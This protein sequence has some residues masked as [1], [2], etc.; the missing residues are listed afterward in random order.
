MSSTIPAADRASRDSKQHTDSRDFILA[1]RGL[2]LVS[3]RLYILL[4]LKVRGH[5][6]GGGAQKLHPCRPLCV[7]AAAGPRQECWEQREEQEDTGETVLQFY[8]LLCES[9]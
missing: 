2:P 1:A 3:P 9:H 5:A 4:R 6:S 8:H 7:G